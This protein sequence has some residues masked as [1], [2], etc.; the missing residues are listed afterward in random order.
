[1]AKEEGVIP[2]NLPSSGMEFDYGSEAE[3]SSI[4]PDHESKKKKKQEEL[5]SEVLA[6]IKEFCRKDEEVKKSA[7]ALKKVRLFV[8]TLRKTVLE[9]LIKANKTKVRYAGMGVILEVRPK[10]TTEKPSDSEIQAKLDEL[11]Q[12]GVRDPRV[13]VKELKTCGKPKTEM[14][15]YKRKIRLNLKAINKQTRPVKKTPKPRVVFES[16]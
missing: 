6:R 9:D 16:K 5:S 13:Y 2:I 1:M 11:I 15:L 10:Q 7:Q 12:S 3:V 4:A 8:R 14:S